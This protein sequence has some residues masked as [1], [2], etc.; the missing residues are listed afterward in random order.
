MRLEHD[1]EA[2]AIYVTL[3]EGSYAYGEDLDAQRR[4]DY[5]ASGAPLGIELLNASSGVDVHDLPEQER[6]GSLLTKHGVPIYARSPSSKR[7][8][9]RR[10]D[11]DS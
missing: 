8:S 11:S 5:D 10:N 9:G 2:D 7:G 6:V 1:T 4:I 3:R